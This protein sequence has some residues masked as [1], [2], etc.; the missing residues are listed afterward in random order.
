[1]IT[2]SIE[3]KNYDITLSDRGAEAIEGAIA[4][5]FPAKNTAA[6]NAFGSRNAAYAQNANEPNGAIG[7]N[8]FNTPPKQTNLNGGSGETFAGAISGKE[9]LF[10][11][12][13]KFLRAAELESELS[14]IKTEIAAALDIKP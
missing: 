3:N 4:A 8:L 1:M 2:I 11:Y 10:A 6:Q 12:I 14:A 13:A 9:L 7:A 5:L